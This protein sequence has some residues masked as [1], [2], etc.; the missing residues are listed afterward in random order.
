ML[1]SRRPK[2]GSSSRPRADPADRP[3]GASPYPR[4]GRARRRAGVPAGMVAVAQGPSGD[5]QALPYRPSCPPPRED[6]AST[7]ITPRDR[8]SGRR[9]TRASEHPSYRRRVGTTRTPI[10][11]AETAP[12]SAEARPSHDARRNAMGFGQ[13]RLVEGSARGGV[14]AVANG[15]RSLP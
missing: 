12:R 7:A 5:R 6:A 3:G 1:R 4:D 8:R 11:F 13:R 15:L 14:R 2:G 10:A 9:C